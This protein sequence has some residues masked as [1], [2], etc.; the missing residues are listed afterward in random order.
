M[1]R[2]ASFTAD[3]LTGKALQQFWLQGYHATSMDDLVEATAVSRHGI[4]STFGGKKKLFLACFD[5]YR[6]AVV[7]PAFNCVEGPDA[8]L[9]TIAAYFEFQISRGE[10]AGLPGPG[11]FVANSATEVAPHDTDTM[12]KVAEHNDR[13]RRGFRNAIARAYAKSG[14]AGDAD[15]T[16]LADVCVIFTNGLWSMSR[17]VTDANDLR[18]A[19]KAFLAVLRGTL[20]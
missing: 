11:C 12:A 17:T 19:V 8:D 5:R 9:A 16:E 4:Y 1:P 2:K 18:R 3:A 7:S 13:L 20:T 15:V 14:S 10:A 6:E